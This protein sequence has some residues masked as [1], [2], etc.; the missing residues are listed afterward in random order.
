M[1]GGHSKTDVID[2]TDILGS[3]FD[4]LT[5]VITDFVEMTD[6]GSDP[7]LKVD[8]DGTGGL[9]SFEQIATLKGVT[10]LT[11][12]AALVSSGNLLAA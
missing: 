12:E 3:A 4:P 11:D 10:G 9:Y 5:D 8:R 6:S 1:I 2:L 7:V